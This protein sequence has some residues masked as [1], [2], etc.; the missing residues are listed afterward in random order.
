MPELPPQLLLRRD[1]WDSGATTTLRQLIREHPDRFY[2]QTWYRHESFLDTPVP[3]H[4]LITAPHYHATQDFLPPRDVPLPLAGRLALAYLHT[5]H[6]VMWGKYCWCAD[7]DQYGQRVYIGTNGHGFEIHR[8]IHLTSR[9][10]TPTC[11]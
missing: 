1:T 7:M 2:A 3:L 5:P 11:L 10:V 8:H 4:P 9:F 6:L